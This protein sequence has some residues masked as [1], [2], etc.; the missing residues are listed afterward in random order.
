MSDL[1][2]ITFTD[3]CM[4]VAGGIDFASVIALARDGEA[5]LKSQAPSRCRVDLGA[6]SSCNSAGTALLVS[7]LRTAA[8]LD[9]T[10]VIERVP[11]NLAALLA[12]GGL[13]MLVP[14]V[15]AS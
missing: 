15:A 3:D 7:W 2:T 13:D 4:R 12:L 1:A 6:V 5:W 9:K 8:A 10:L 14:H 11:E